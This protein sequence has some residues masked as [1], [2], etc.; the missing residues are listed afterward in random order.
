MTGARKHVYNGHY[1]KLNAS[2]SD[3]LKTALCSGEKASSFKPLECLWA[4]IPAYGIVTV[5]L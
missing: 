4:T 5:L 1:T 3:I 2:F